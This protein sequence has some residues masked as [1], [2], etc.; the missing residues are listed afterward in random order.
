MS[1]VGLELGTKASLSVQLLDDKKIQGSQTRGQNDQDT[2]G[3]RTCKVGDNSFIP[4]GVEIF[5]HI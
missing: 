4:I 3:E 2:H 5:Q 1:W